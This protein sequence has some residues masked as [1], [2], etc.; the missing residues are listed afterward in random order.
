MDTQ[1][2]DYYDRMDAVRAQASYCL[3]HRKPLFAPRTGI[4]HHC[5]HIIY[6]PGGISVRKAATTLVTGC[7]FCHISFCE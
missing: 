6:S 5:G 3:N 2:K 4:C 1:I 7:P